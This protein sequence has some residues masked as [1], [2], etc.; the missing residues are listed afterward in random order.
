MHERV[1]LPR[2]SGPQAAAR[3]AGGDGRRHGHRR[4]HAHERDGGDRVCRFPRAYRAAAAHRRAHFEGDQKPSRLFAV[5]RSGLSD[6]FT[7]ER[8]AL[9]RRE[10]AHPACHADRQQP[11]G[12]AVYPRRAVHR[13]APARQRQAARDAQASARPRQYADRGRARR[14]HDARGGLYRGHRPGGGRPWRAR[15]RGGHAGG[16]HGERSEPDRSVSEREKEDRNAENAAR[17]ER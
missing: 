13:A 16:G 14:G 5:G 2:V 4:V 10:P 1:L 3:V 11:D 17:G 15:R 7:R 8:N 6:A 9:R 12:C